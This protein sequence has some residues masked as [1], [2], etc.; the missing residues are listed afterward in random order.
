MN[1]EEIKLLVIKAIDDNKEKIHEIAQGI[2]H[3]PEYGYK[4][5][6]TTEAICKFL[7]EELNLKVEKN[8]AVTGCKAVLNENKKGPNI[9]ILGE[10][11]GIT[12]KE[13]QHSNDIGASHSCGHNKQIAGMLGAAL[14]LLKSGVLDFL[15]GKITIMATPAEEFIELEYRQELKNNGEI[16]Y[17]G[18]KQ[19]LVKRGYF[20]DVDMSMMFH[21]LDMK[22]KK[23][24]VGPESNGFIGKKVQFIG[25]ESHAG[26]APYDGINALNAAMLAINNVNALRE[27]FKESERVRFHPILT[28]AGDIVNVVPAD[29][30]ME[31]YVRA[32][33][34]DGMID[35]NE[36]INKA[37]LAGGMAVGAEVV[38]TEIPGYLP[39]RRYK[40][41]DNLFSDNLVELGVKR[42]EIVDGGDFT[43]SFDFGDI[44][45]LMPTLHPM[46][47]GVSGALHTRHFETFDDDLSC[48]IPAKTMAM[49]IVD[50]LFDGAKGANEI[51]ADFTP[52]MTKKE[53]L[54]FLSKY[55][56]TL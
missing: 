26:S 53:Y 51:L 24:L 4:E 1:K 39:I 21:S 20:D 9:S 34:I 48:I 28:K 55:D 15:D 42:E 49:T 47:G 52:I 41:L 14:G 8:I 22:G 56:K 33:T 17:F 30:H 54:D 19:E 37:L 25:K 40:S 44:S 11:D 2:Y 35:A 5:Y 10:L 12:C 31:S 16:T 43:G 27:T 13:H 3:N 36:R 45:H 18:G 7:D 38:I 6:K 46:I 23:A 29:V 50:L 32:R